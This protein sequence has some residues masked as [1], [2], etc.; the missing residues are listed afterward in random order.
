MPGWGN[1]RFLPHHALPGD[2]ETTGQH[3][4]N[5]TV[6]RSVHIGWDD[7]RIWGGPEY[8]PISRL[9]W[10]WECC[11]Q[12]VTLLWCHNAC[13]VWNRIFLA[14]LHLFWQ[15]L[16]VYSLSTFLPC[17]TSHGLLSFSKSHS[18]YVT[19]HLCS[20]ECDTAPQLILWLVLRYVWGH[21]I[22]GNNHAL[23]IRTHSG[24]L[25]VDPQHSWLCGGI[26]TGY[27]H[28]LRWQGYPPCI[29]P[30][31]CIHGWLPREVSIQCVCLEFTLTP[32][33]FNRVLLVCVWSLGACPY[34][35]CF[36]KKKDIPGLRTQVDGQRRAEHRKG[37]HVYHHKIETTWEIIYK[38]GYIV[39]SKAI[40]S[41]LGQ[42]RLPPHM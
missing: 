1:S 40:D 41:V 21:S 31:L 38:K 12:T 30:I 11:C 23:Q 25:V 6:W 22:R 13:T 24:T 3:V 4:T 20:D 27:F 7:Q 34:P 10:C 37:D 26:P 32:C 29:P 33:A 8:P 14:T 28:L 18:H 36:I 9:P 42:N 35:R 2:V 19:C 5:P 15:P 39:N 17:S 16:Q